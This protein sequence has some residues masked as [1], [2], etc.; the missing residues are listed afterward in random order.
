MK[1]DKKLNT[2]L[3]Y[4]AWVGD[5]V[6]AALGGLF[7]A[8]RNVRDDIMNIKNID[9]H[10]PF[11]K[12]YKKYFVEHLKKHNNDKLSTRAFGQYMKDI[13]TY[14]P[15]TEINNKNLDKFVREMR[16]AYSM[17]VTYFEKTE[18]Q[19]AVPQ[20]CRFGDYI[21]QFASDGTEWCGGT[22]GNG[23]ISIVD[24][25]NKNFKPV[26][27]I[28]PQLSDYLAEIVMQKAK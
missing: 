5:Y 6:I 11:L 10:V 28:S 21:M 9:K 14:N 20:M 24:N 22:R 25:T 3:G 12:T 26:A 17:S 7:V 8:G 4:I 2:G 15:Y 1:N 27:S 19:R 18:H 16:D 13:N 23:Y